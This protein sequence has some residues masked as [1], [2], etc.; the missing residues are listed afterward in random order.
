MSHFLRYF[1]GLYAFNVLELGFGGAPFK[2]ILSGHPFCLSPFRPG[3][4][5]TVG[6]KEADLD[7]DLDIGGH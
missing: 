7:T 2:Q 1:G 5:A 4:G 6:G 3:A